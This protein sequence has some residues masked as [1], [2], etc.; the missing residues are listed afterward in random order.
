MSSSLSEN[1][2]ARDH[3]LFYRTLQLAHASTC[4][5]LNDIPPDFF[6]PRRLPGPSLPLLTAP[7]WAW[8]ACRT[9]VREGVE[10]FID[11][12][13]NASLRQTCELPIEVDRLIDKSADRSGCCDCWSSIAVAGDE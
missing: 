9:K 2:V 8:V 3:I 11:N 13:P 4:A 12:K 10:A 5:R 6:A 7:C 1:D